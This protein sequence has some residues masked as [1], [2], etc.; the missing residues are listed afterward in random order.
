MSNVSNIQARLQAEADAFWLAA[1][2]SDEF[3]HLRGRPEPR[4]MVRLQ[5]PGKLP[6]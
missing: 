6:K 4:V 2:R 5:P 1:L 3:K